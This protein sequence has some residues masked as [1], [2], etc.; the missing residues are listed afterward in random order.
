MPKGLTE[1]YIL[2]P[3]RVKE[4]YVY[5]LVTLDANAHK[6]MMIF[7]NRTRTV[8]TLVRALRLLDVRVTGLHGEMKQQDRLNSLGRFR[9]GAAR[10]L[11]ATDVASR[12]LDIPEVAMVV[13]IDIPRDPDDYVHRVGRTARAGKAGQ[14]VTFVGERDVDLVHAIEHRTGSKMEEY[15][16]V[17]EDRVLENLN[18]VSSAVREA[19]INMTDEGFGLQRAVQEKKWG[20]KT[21]RAQRAQRTQRTQTKIA[22]RTT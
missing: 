17:S 11:V 3:P 21:Q 5:D 6:A 4:P 2:V 13:N 1:S 14:A 22:K 12:G 16:L 10:I 9:A 15:T 18:R 7:C 8:E 20:T 19:V